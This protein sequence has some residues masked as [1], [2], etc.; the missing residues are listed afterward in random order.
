MW[1][2]PITSWATKADIS[3][4][5]CGAPSSGLGPSAARNRG[6]GQQSW[7]VPI[8]SGGPVSD[9]IDSLYV[10]F[11]RWH[12]RPPTRTHCWWNWAD[13]LASSSPKP[14]QGALAHRSRPLQGKGTNAQA[15]E[16]SCGYQELWDNCWASKWVTGAPFLLCSEHP[17]IGFFK[18]CGIWGTQCSC[19]VAG[20]GE[21]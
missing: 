1:G 7:V 6:R 21:K 14:T 10:A 2:G 3:P 18:E 13:V 5:C 16:V 19:N 4:I 17:H 20:L 11:P 15:V 12:F 8:K 9:G